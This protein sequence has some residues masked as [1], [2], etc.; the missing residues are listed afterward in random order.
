MTCSG[1]YFYEFE[2]IFQGLEGR[3]RNPV[4]VLVDLLN[5]P[6]DDQDLNSS[7]RGLLNWKHHPEKAIDHVVIGKGKPGGCWQ[8]TA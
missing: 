7:A 2:C 1:I 4:A 3:S 5:H 6:Y 8:V